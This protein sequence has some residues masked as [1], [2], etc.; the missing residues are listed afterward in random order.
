[1]AAAPVLS[2]GIISGQVMIDINKDGIGDIPSSF[3]RIDLLSAVTGEAVVMIGTGL[4][5]NFTFY[6]VPFG[7]YII[8]QITPR[9]YQVVSSSEMSNQAKK[10]IRVT[11]SDDV[12]S[13]SGIFF[14][15]R[16]DDTDNSDGNSDSPNIRGGAISNLDEN[17]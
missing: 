5:G 9:G 6:E 4:D 3:T 12:P 17:V 1:M 8:K 13:L 14:I 15:N 2:R 7:D 16:L 10:S 11:L